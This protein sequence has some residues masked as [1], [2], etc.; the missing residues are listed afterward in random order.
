MEDG[1][2]PGYMSLSSG[3]EEDIEEERRLAYVGMTR[4]EKELIM[5]GAKARMMRGETQ[6]NPVSRFIKEIPS[7]YLDG[8]VPKSRKSFRDEYEDDRSIGRGGAYPGSTYIKPVVRK[9]SSVALEEKR[10]TDSPQSTKAV[11]PRT[12][13]ASLGIQKGSDKTAAPSSID[14]A[15]GDRVRHFK[16]GAGT[17]TSI[18]KEPRDYKVTV[19]FDAHGTKVMYASFAKLAKE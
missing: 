5:T 3:D 2:F 10:S 13:F 14:Y 11:F 16:F 7:E 1:L 9:T 12:S 17:V 15:V 8:Y 6:F 18:V 19:D 4:A